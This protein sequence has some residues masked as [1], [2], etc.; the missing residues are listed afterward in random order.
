MAM[1]FW[2]EQAERLPEPER[3][4]LL[5]DPPFGQVFTDH[6]ITI[7]WTRDL[8]WHDARLR[9]YGPVLWTR[10]PRSSTMARPYSRD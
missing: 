3:D 7:T 5:S 9:P 10:P 8:G 6:M 1:E 2:V 4:R